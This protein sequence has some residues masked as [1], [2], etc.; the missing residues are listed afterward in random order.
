MLREKSSKESERV[1]S[2]DCNPS[3]CCQAAAA[4][5]ACTVGT[6]TSSVEGCVAWRQ[7]EV[8]VGEGEWDSDVAEE[9]GWDSDAQS[10]RT[11]LLPVV[12]ASAAG[13]L[14]SPRC[15]SCAVAAECC[16]WRRKLVTSASQQV[17]GSDE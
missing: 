11:L 5:V 14:T 12:F 3:G 9:D 17:A 2:S 15:S 16:S 1:R 13:A 4:V 6:V 10:E 7:G 8:G